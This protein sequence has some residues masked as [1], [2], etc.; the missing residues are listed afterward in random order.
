MIARRLVAICALACA[1]A[2]AEP[3]VIYSQPGYQSPVHAASD[4]LLLLPGYGF[5]KG[6][7]VFYRHVPDGSDIPVQVVSYENVPVA[8]TVLLPPEMEAGST[9]EIRVRNAKNEWSNAVRINDARPLWLSPAAV[10]STAAVASLP[11]QF[12]I[13]GRNL[14]SVTVRLT[15]P[16][17]LEIRAQP[18]DGEEPTLRGYV[19]KVPLPRRLARGAYRVEVSRDGTSWAALETQ[20]LMVLPD[21][22]ASREL[23]LDQPELG[24]C[25]PNDGRDDTA[26]LIAALDAAAPGGGTVLLAAGAWDFIGASAGMT[27]GDGIVMPRGVSL[28]G[29]GNRLTRVVRHDTWRSGSTNAFLTLLG[30]NEVRDIAFSD[31][32][33]FRQNEA[34]RPIL[35]LGDGKAPVENVVITGNVFGRT[36]GPI[37]DSGVPMR[38]LFITYNEL[39]AFHEALQLGGNRFNVHMPFRIDDSVIAYNTFKPG[40]S[41]DV[42]ARQGAIASELG[43]SNRLDFSHNT[44]DGVA[45]EY[46]DSPR[47]ARGWR[48][49]FFFHMNGNH[50]MTLV[51]ENRITCSG[52]KAG[53][54]EAIAY[55]NNANTFALPEARVILDATKSTVSIR[56]PLKSLQNGR[57]V[58]L[59][60]YYVGHWVQVVS[61]AGLG[62]SRRIVGYRIESG[63]K[64]T[65]TVVPAWDVVPRAGESRIGVGREYWQVYTLANVVDHR[66]P[67]CQKT[68]RTR[69]K[70]GVIGL[71]AQ[72]ADSVVA[73]NRQYDTDGILMQNAYVADDPACKECVAQN[74]FQSS[75]EIRDNLI[76]GEYQWDSACSISGI[77]SSYAASP[78]PSS[79]PPVLGFGVSI[80][81]NTIRQAD[82]F[83]GGAID[84]ASTWYVGPPPHK[85]RL[86]D[87]A[88]IHH[89][90]IRDVS[91]ALPRPAC[92]YEQWVRAGVRLDAPH[93]LSRTVLYANSCQNVAK[94]VEDYGTDTVRVCPSSASSSCECRERR[95][96]NK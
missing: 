66:Q 10:Y 46:L 61:G 4:D 51:S 81:H 25:H 76:D 2:W 70:G 47:D 38:R 13:V 36:N 32:H 23:P 7:V 74:T 1:P 33:A 50:E 31:G 77:M 65:F 59:A 94:G 75:V 56:G 55:D 18:D 37:S 43:A 49:A 15:G 40:S 30:D 84:F 64:V 63:D 26:C 52:D 39:G 17:R 22:V 54:G 79:P 90:V 45:T 44:A 71:W 92:Q 62:Q 14:D 67:L 3:P 53:D 93:A 19:A 21:P 85:W 42:A 20:Q 88:L 69:P 12:K 78:T 82:G 95:S 34:P 41:L 68:N 11:R 16:E 29:A 24:G 80:A 91:G 35:K 9:Y 96:I 57:E 8:L 60:S 6:D 73:G 27:N 87:N 28:R 48:A 58:P 86:I 89:N 5:S 72:T 83:K